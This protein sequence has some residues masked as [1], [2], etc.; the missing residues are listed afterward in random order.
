MIEVV[1]RI[2]CIIIG[3]LFGLF[4]TGYIYGKMNNVDIRDYG[5]GNAGTTNALR[6]LG[7]KAGAITYMGDML[8]ALLAGLLVRLVLVMAFDMDSDFI[9]IALLYTGLGVVLGHNYPFYM[10]FKGGKGI[11][12][13]SGVILS[14]GDWKLA[15]LAFLTFVI[16]CLITRYVSLSSICMVVGFMVEFIIF[17]QLDITGISK[18]SDY[19]A[20]CYILV[21]LFTAMAV[22]RHKENIVRLIK[23]T[24]RKL[25]QKKE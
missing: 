24:E 16:I 2:C 21:I 23:G 22:F 12:A 9:F 4:Q 14:L 7:K 5:S 15:V 8:K 6:V 25:G 18:Y 13:T 17:S 3:Y 1:V 10:N 20:E 19:L 11:A